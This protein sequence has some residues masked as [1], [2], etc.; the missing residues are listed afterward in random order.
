MYSAPFSSCSEISFRCNANEFSSFSSMMRKL[1]VAGKSGTRQHLKT[2]KKTGKTS[3]QKLCI[4]GVRVCSATSQS[5]GKLESLLADQQLVKA[6]T[7]LKYGNIFPSEYGKVC[8]SY[9]FHKQFLHSS[10]MEYI[11]SIGFTPKISKNFFCANHVFTD[12]K[13]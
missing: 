1:K 5:S 10:Y 8:V 3:V 11:E 6:F 4:H 12:K 7:N 2:W 9:R 13:S